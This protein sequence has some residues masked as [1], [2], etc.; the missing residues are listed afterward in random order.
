LSSPG[1][2]RFV[3]S[4]RSA[5][6]FQEKWFD[7][8]VLLF[9]FGESKATHLDELL[10]EATK[11][12][13]GLMQ[14]PEITKHVRR[15]ACLDLDLHAVEPERRGQLTAVSRVARNISLVALRLATIEAAADTQAA[16]R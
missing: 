15:L 4:I 11:T 12:S 3:T 6:S 10:E 7:G 5:G 8:Y 13:A 16:R 9:H 2:R 14:Q 1:A